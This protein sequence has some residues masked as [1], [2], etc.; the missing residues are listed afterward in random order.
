MTNN[1]ALPVDGS[2]GVNIRKEPLQSSLDRRTFLADNREIV[3][4]THSTEF[5]VH[6]NPN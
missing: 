3:G 4:S 1:S 2:N 6:T 5:G